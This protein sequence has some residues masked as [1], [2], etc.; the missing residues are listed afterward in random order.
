MSMNTE[1]LCH[2]KKPKLNIDSDEGGSQDDESAPWLNVLKD[3]RIHNYHLTRT[4]KQAARVGGG[5]N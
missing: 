2:N 3:E 1:M 4:E 5:R